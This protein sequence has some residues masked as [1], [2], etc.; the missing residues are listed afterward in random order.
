MMHA[1]SSSSADPASGDEALSGRAAKNALTQEQVAAM[2][3][4]V[5][6][7][8]ATEASATAQKRPAP[9]FYKDAVPVREDPRSHVRKHAKYFRLMRDPSGLHERHLYPWEDM[10]I[11][12]DRRKETVD[13]LEKTR[14]IK[15]LRGDEGAH[16]H[17]DILAG[18][19]EAD[20]RDWR[21]YHSL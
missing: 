12:K 10:I 19:D 4:R 16:S 7:A 8:L 6:S 1:S 2:H 11:A 13:A 21:K 5:A 3:A 20:D 15:P 17:P 9:P 14:E 18:E